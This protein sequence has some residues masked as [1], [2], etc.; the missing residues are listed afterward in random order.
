MAQNGKITGT[1]DREWRFRE[2]AQKLK[3]CAAN[4]EMFL[5]TCKAVA[6]EFNNAIPWLQWGTDPKRAMSFFPA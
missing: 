5:E 1:E 4:F 6:K 3:S 2:L